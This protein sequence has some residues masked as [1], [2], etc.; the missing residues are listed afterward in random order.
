MSIIDTLLQSPVLMGVFI[1]ITSIIVITILLRTPQGK[2]KYNLS[3]ASLPNATSATELSADDHIRLG[4]EAAAAYDFDKA[5]SHFQM[6]LK[7]KGK[8]AEPALHFKIG[9]LFV[10]KADYK[11]AITAFKNVIALNPDKTDAH[12]ELARIYQ[13]QGELEQAQQELNRVIEI[14]PDH[15]EALRFKIKL[16]AQEENYQQALPL[17]RKLIGQS[18]QPLKYRAQLAEFLAKLKQFNDAR[19]EYEALLELDPGNRIFYK[20]KIGQL[21]FEQEHYA[22]AIEAFKA[23]LQEQD[24]LMNEETLATVRSQLAASLCNEGVKLFEAGNYIDAIQLYQEA[25][26]YDHTN[27]D[28]HYNLGKAYAKTHQP[29]NAIKHFETSLSFNP[30]DV[31]CL[32]ELAI[33]QDERGMFKEAVAS[34]ER[35]LELSPNNVLALFGLGTMYGVQGELDKSIHYLS[36]AIR[37]DPHFVD[38]IYNLGVALER[39]K[40]FNKATQAYQRV[41]KLDGN[42]EKALSNLMH[43]QHLK[44]RSR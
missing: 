16:F 32:Y 22:Q 26:L 2:A 40:D 20:S 8:T 4:N 7:L 37:L 3:G 13:L 38:A 31:G 15:E 39:K 14:E 35:V 10:Q 19:V 44:T 11:N 34:Y 17:I 6:A 5:L 36:E 1:L 28:I 23:V 21:L 9:R 25:L 30:D 24:L 12:Y 42:H 27:A 29:I 41:L 33:L 18:R 43:I